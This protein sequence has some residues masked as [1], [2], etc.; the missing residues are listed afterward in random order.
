MPQQRSGPV[1]TGCRRPASCRP[2][3]APRGSG[4]RIRRAGRDS[5]FIVRMAEEFNRAQAATRLRDD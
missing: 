1:R 5:P 4:R 3:L 2:E